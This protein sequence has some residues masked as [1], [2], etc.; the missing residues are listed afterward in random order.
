MMYCLFHFSN[1]ISMFR[2]GTSWKWRISLIILLI[3]SSRTLSSSELVYD[4]FH[5]VPL[6]VLN[7]RTPGT[8]FNLITISFSRVLNIC[9]VLIV[10]A[11][12]MIQCGDVEQNPGPVL[13]Y[14][15]CVKTVG[16]SFKNN[17][18]IFSLNCRSIVGQNS[19]LK[20]L[21][22]DLGKNTIFGFTETW[23]KMNDDIRFWEV[24]SENFQC[25]RKNRNL[26][27]HD[28]TSG[29]GLLLYIPRSFKPKE[30]SDLT[31]VSESRFESIWVECQF[32]KKSI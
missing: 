7:N 17:V 25:F 15:E 8:A 2:E 22:D 13:K 11:S 16:A 19:T 27:L 1:L 29:G 6:F 12:I 31:T 30:R 4:N 3:L 10:K 9:F 32:N 26:S 20:Q 18:K 23:L 14:A 5:E 24:R 21:M 28:K